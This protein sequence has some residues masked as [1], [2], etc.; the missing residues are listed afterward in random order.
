MQIDDLKVVLLNKS[1]SDVEAALNNFDLA[2]FD[3]Y[4]NN[5]LHYYVKSYKSVN[6][7]AESIIKLFVD[8]GIDINTKQSKMPRRAALHFAVI[9]RS[10]QIFDVL[11]N[12]DADVN[13]QDGDGNVALHN[14]VFFFRNDDSYFIET[15]IAKRARVDI[16]NN[17]GVTPKS[18][19]DTIANYDSK[20]FFV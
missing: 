11:I 3:K 16:A 1:L 10:K 6:I 9:D 17:Y 5:I 20:R 4:G 8:R 14:A 7:P 18:L 19:S 12:N 13:I 2:S 15:L